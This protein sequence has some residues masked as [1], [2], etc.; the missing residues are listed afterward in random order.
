MTI[1]VQHIPNPQIAG[2]IPDIAT[3]RIEVFQEYPYLYK[4]NLTYEQHYLQGFLTETHALV[5]I[6]T[7]TDHDQIIGVATALP[8]QSEADILEGAASLFSDHGIVPETVFYYS[9]ILVKPRYRGQ[10]IAK[11]FYRLRESYAKSLGY[12]TVCFAAILKP[13]QDPQRP[14]VYYDP[15]PYWQSMGFQQRKDLLIYYQWPT[16]QP[17]GS[18]IEQEHTLAFWLKAL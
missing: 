7:D 2:Y 8:L 4:G 6:A 14:D 10:G 11:Q 16:I 5:L 12:Q 15:A 18:I 17:D 13:E 9:E 3:M 1:Q